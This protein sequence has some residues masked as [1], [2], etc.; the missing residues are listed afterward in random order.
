MNF[1]ENTVDLLRNLH[2]YIY[3]ICNNVHVQYSLQT[4]TGHHPVNIRMVVTP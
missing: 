1:T 2:I 4:H 3:T